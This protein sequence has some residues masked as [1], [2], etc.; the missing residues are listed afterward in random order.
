MV[1]REVIHHGT[2]RPKLIRGP[3]IPDFTKGKET[4]D[5]PSSSP[6][7]PAPPKSAGIVAFFKSMF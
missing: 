7:T 6:S 5:I 2:F 4:E 1:G 3:E